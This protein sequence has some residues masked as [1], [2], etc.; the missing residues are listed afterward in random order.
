MT[1][2]VDED[3]SLS[4][5]LPKQISD[6]HGVGMM[7]FVF[8]AMI[9]AGSVFCSIVLLK[10]ALDGFKAHDDIV[11]KII[12]IAIVILGVPLIFVLTNVVANLIGRTKENDR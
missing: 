8:K 11:S 1:S 6:N 3:L 4:I 12:Y 2:W 7:K 5:Y 9:R 10:I